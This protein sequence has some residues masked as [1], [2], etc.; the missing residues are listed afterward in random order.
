MKTTTASR[1]LALRWASAGMTLIEL[2]MVVVILGVLAGVGAFSYSAY[3]RRSRSQEARTMLASIAARED[4]YRGEFSTYCA[5]GAMGSP[6]SLGLSN[7]WPTI[8]PTS[9]RAPFLTTSMPQEWLQLGFRPTGDVRYRYIVIAGTPPTAPPSPYDVGFSS[10]PNQDLW[11]VTEAYGNLDGD[12]VI[13]TFGLYSGNS[14]TMRIVN[15]T[16]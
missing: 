13:S 10:A 5:A 11:Y 12:G 16:E 4:A 9:A 3:L 15:E 1:R 7:A 6:T 14:N 8:A 2:M